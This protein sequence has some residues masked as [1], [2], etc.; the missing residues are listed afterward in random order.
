MKYV[1][2]LQEVKD[3]FVEPDFQLMMEESAFNFQNEEPNLGND[4]LSCIEESLSHSTQANN[5]FPGMIAAFSHP[6]DASEEKLVYNVHTWHC[7]FS[8]T[9]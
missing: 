7:Q 4:L 2:I 6:T 9:F 8:M 5:Y 3:D 1:I